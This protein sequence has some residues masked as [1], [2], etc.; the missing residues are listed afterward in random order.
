MVAE[1]H[2][3]ETG[4]P[5]VNNA[6]LDS[7]TGGTP[8]GAQNINQFTGGGTATVGTVGV[9]APGST[10]YMD[11][12]NADSAGWYSTG[13]DF[14]MSPSDNFGFGIY[15]SAAALG[16]ASGKDIFMLGAGSGAFTLGLSSNGWSAGSH[17]VSWIGGDGGVS[18]SFTAN[19]WVHLA[20]IRTNGSARFYINGVAQG[21][22][23][24]G[25]PAHWYG[26]HGRQTG[27]HRLFRRSA[28]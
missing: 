28:R 1:Y 13:S 5:D 11:V 6:P 7:A 23:Y 26:A 12:S 19:E 8:S 14:S 16:P 4:S 20:L 17:F 3:G 10:A 25:A 2:L 15:V 27:W 22:A 9:Y 21:S 18:G 24:T